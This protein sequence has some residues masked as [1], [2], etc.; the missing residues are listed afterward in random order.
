MLNSGQILNSEVSF[1][2]D[3]KEQSHLGLRAQ[4]ELEGKDGSQLSS[5]KTKGVRSPLQKQNPE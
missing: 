5:L 2:L 4:G 1:P 3:R